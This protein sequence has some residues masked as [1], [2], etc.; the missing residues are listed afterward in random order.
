MDWIMGDFL[1][2]YGVGGLIAFG[3]IYRDRARRESKYEELR[4]QAD[5]ML[6][7]SVRMKWRVMS[8]QKELDGM[9]E[10][11]TLD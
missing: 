6:A 7:D 10:R 2:G 4:E 3:L 9:K 1:I 8:I 11:Y 5:A